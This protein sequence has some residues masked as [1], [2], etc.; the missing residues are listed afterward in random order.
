MAT[1]SPPSSVAIAGF[2]CLRSSSAGWPGLRAAELARTG[3]RAAELPG[4]EL[5]HA[6]P[7]AAAL[8]SAGLRAAELPRAGE[9]VRPDLDGGGS[10]QHGRSAGERA[11]RIGPVAAARVHG[12]RSTRR[13]WGAQEGEGVHGT[14]EEEEHGIVLEMAKGKIVIFMCGS[15]LSD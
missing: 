11:W 9:R 4:P 12:G 7:S 3:L 1:A 10:E 14:E 13:R 2:V 6:G 5:A 15:H 8:A